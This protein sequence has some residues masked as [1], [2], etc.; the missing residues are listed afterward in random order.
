MNGRKTTK[1]P[2]GGLSLNYRFAYVSALDKH[3][4]LE[5]AKGFEPSTPTLARLGL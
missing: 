2:S 5:R 3:K 4:I 1:P